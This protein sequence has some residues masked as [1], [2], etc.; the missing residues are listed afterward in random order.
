[1]LPASFFA[2][3]DDISG[4]RLRR[5]RTAKRRRWVREI[6]ATSIGAWHKRRYNRQTVP[7][8]GLLPAAA[9][10]EHCAEAEGDEGQ[11]GWFGDD[12]DL[13]EVV[14]LARIPPHRRIVRGQIRELGNAEGVRVAAKTEQFENVAAGA[15][16]RKGA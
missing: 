15:G 1:M 9:Q 11:R 14:E 5:S 4:I 3:R 12:G 2:G 7:L 16:S 8:P 13:A 6:D 10:Q